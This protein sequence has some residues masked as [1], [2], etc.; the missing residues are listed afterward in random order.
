M[1]PV[2]QQLGYDLLLFS[3]LFTLCVIIGMLT[4]PF[5]YALFYFK[6]IGHQDVSMKDIYDSSVPYVFLMLIVLG[7]CIVF[8]RIPLWLPNKMIK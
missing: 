3:L 2:A 7:L 6:G 4:P 8:P 1:F 5:G